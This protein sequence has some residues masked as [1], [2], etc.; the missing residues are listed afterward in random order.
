VGI[1]KA[2]NLP[3]LK[4]ALNDAVI[5][6]RRII[7]EA[8]LDKPRELEVAV[9]GNDL[10]SASPVGEISYSS[11]FYD[12]ETKY[13]EGRAGLSIPASIPA[14]IAHQ[15]Q[16]LAIMAFKAIDAAGLARVDFFYDGSN[17]FIN[18][19]N[20]MPGFTTTSMY[21]KLWEA[22]GIRYAELIQHLIQLALE[23]SP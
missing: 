10:P 12:Y 17:L 7:V 6:D 20:T 9:L 19:I 3:E 15:C 11:D 21:P 14:E 2:K 4:S 5:Y 16:H 13:T 23:R 1:S 8:G 22:A 18:E